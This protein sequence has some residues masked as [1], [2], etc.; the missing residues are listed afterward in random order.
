MIHCSQDSLRLVLIPHTQ[1]N[2]VRGHLSQRT[3][4]AMCLTRIAVA[5]AVLAYIQKWVPGHRTGV[6]A[7]NS[8]HADRSFLVREMP[9]VVDWLHYR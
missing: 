1:R 4:R 2:M 7:G 6:L 8:V 5:K 9:E 3:I